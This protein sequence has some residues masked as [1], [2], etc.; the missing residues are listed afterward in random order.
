MSYW[1]LMIAYTLPV[2]IMVFMFF[3][4]M[5]LYILNINQGKKGFLNIIGMVV[6]LSVVAHWTMYLI[7]TSI[8]W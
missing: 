8:N 2:T 4:N 6:P 1:E 3:F 7:I 5:H